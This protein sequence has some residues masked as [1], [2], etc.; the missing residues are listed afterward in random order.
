MEAP[1]LAEDLIDRFRVDFLL[2]DGTSPLSVTVAAAPGP[3]CNTG[4][5]RRDRRLDPTETAAKIKG[6]DERITLDSVNL[7]LELGSDVNAVNETGDTALHAAAANRFNSVI[8]LLAERGANLEAKNKRGLTP[9]Q[10]AL[11]APPRSSLTGTIV[12]E[13]NTADLLRALG[14]K[15]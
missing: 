4:R 15:H 13:A 9:L 6:E 14:A 11:Q 7:L 1:E 5:D 12:Q 8:Q 10:I 2:E 3:G